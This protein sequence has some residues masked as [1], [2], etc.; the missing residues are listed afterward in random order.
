MSVKNSKITVAW[1]AYY[2]GDNKTVEQIIPGQSKS[3]DRSSITESKTQEE[4]SGL[5]SFNDDEI[6]FEF[7][8]LYWALDTANRE[9]KGKVVSSKDGLIRCV[10]WPISEFRFEGRAYLTDLSPSTEWKIAEHLWKSKLQPSL[11]ATLEKDYV[12]TY[13]GRWRFDSGS[14]IAEVMSCDFGL[15]RISGIL[16]DNKSN[17]TAST[18]SSDLG[19]LLDEMVPTRTP[20]Q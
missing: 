3:D 20:A 6:L 7:A 17:L 15:F 2:C 1:L 4:S 19:K 5:S 14:F 9:T 11:D 12:P 18:I 10:I 13:A 8:K 16:K